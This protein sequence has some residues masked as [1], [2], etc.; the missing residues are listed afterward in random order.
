[1]RE[2]MTM[3]VLFPLLAVL[4]IALYAGGLGVIFMLLEST[5]LGEWG[6]VLLGVILVVGVPVVAYLLQQRVERQR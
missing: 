3:S 2:R 4:L 1:M 5:G 6:P